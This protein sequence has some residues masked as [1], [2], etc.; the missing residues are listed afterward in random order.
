MS[1][2]FD[3][4]NYHRFLHIVEII[5]QAP[6]EHLGEYIKFFIDLAE[7]LNI[8]PNK[9]AIEVLKEVISSIDALTS[10]MPAKDDEI[11]IMTIHKSKGLEFSIVFVLD[12][13]KYVFSNNCGKKE[14]GNSDQVLNLYYVAITRAKDAVYFLNASERSTKSGRVFKALPS[15]LY[16]LPGLK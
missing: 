9:K 7:L 14:S 6:V 4:E 12:L 3:F 5:Y 16:F 8:K 10:F 2:E 1:K 13:Y 15:E 11:N